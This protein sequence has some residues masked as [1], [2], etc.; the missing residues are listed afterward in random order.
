MHFAV[1]S[2]SILETIKLHTTKI[3]KGNK[4]YSGPIVRFSPSKDIISITDDKTGK[5]IEFKISEL[6]S[7]ITDGERISCNKIGTCDELERAKDYIKRGW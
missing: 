4:T 3:V 1:L 7:A 2:L 5:V 6:T